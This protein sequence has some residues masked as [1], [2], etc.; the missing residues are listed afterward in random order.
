MALYR[1]L[2]SAIEPAADTPPTPLRE[3]KRIVYTLAA[4]F[5]L[6]SFGGGFVVQSLLALW[7]FQRFDLSIATTATIFFWLGMIT[8]K[9]LADMMVAVIAPRCSSA[10]RPVKT[11]V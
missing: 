6:D 8:R 5:S 11:W 9:T 4:L 10:A 2:S 3:S 1:H 7:L